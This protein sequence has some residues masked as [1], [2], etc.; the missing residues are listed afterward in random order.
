[1]MNNTEAT[2]IARKLAAPFDA[3]AVRWKPMKVSGTRA[4]AAAYIESRAV[5]G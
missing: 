2:A 4:L 3:A 1:M 5:P